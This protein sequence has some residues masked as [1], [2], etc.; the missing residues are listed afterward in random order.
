MKKNKV[1]V[2]DFY[3][4]IFGKNDFVDLDYNYEEDLYSHEGKR[5]KC[6]YR[7]CP[8]SIFPTPMCDGILI[9]IPQMT[10]MPIVNPE[11]PIQTLCSFSERDKDLPIMGDSGAFSYSN[12]DEPPMT[13]KYGR[14]IFNKYHVT[15]GQSIDHT[16]MKKIRPKGSGNRFKWR[17]LSEAEQDDRIRITMRN[18]ERLIRHSDE[19]DFIPMGVAQGYNEATYVASVRHLRKIGY[20]DICLGGMP[21]D[22]TRKVLD[23]VRA[24]APYLKHFRLVHLL[25]VLR[26]EVMPELRQLGITSVDNTT[27]Y[28]TGFRGFRTNYLAKNG[29]WYNS[30]R[31]PLFHKKKEYRGNEK[32][33]RLILENRNEVLRFVSVVNRKPT[34]AP[35]LLRKLR[36]FKERWGKNCYYPTMYD[37]ESDYVELLA[38]RPWELCDCEHCQKLGLHMAIFDNMQ[39][40]HLRGCHN[41]WL[42]YQRYKKTG[43]LGIAFSYKTRKT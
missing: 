6:H 30:I 12:L 7:T 9:G 19:C 20:E 39:R 24:M 43:V 3:F 41:T 23:Q 26:R 25:G 33:I 38:D 11:T 18:A 1:M 31:L 36:E 4:P 10:K 14:N 5:D 34:L 16:A 37:V 42:L 27:P 22:S 21:S 2:P 17:I 35:S 32:V 8:V 40:G 13:T 15:Y 29:Q 28:A